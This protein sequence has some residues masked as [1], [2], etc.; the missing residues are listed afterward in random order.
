LIGDFFA[1]ACS[2]RQVIMTYWLPTGAGAVKHRFEAAFGAEQATAMRQAL[3]VI[4]SA[5][6]ARAFQDASDTKV[7]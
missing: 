2:W 5:A 7:V 6:F 4:V 3:T 1:F